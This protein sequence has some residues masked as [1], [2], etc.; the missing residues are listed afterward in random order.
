MEHVASAP[1]KRTAP[2]PLGGLTE[3][4]WPRLAARLGEARR[5][6]G[7]SQGDAAR[8]LDLSRP[9]VSAMERGERH[10]TPLE[11][12]RLARLYRR[13]VEWFLGDERELSESLLLTTENL[14]TKDMQQ[15]LRSA[16][17]LA[18]A[19]RPQ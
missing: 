19:A 10:V 2:D 8:V 16:E 1:N 14:A 3:S 7:L 9:T 18:S 17:I 6:I 15:V 12:R 5:H 13:P 4:E 11:L